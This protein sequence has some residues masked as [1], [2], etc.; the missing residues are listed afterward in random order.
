LKE[1]IENA[2]VAAEKPLKPKKDTPSS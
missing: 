1:I 2:T